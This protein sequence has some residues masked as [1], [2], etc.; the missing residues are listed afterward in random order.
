MAHHSAITY[1]SL[2]VVPKLN[3][4]GSGRLYF[5]IKV[6]GHYCFLLVSGARGLKNMWRTTRFGLRMLEASLS[7]S[8]SVSDTVCK[9]INET[10][11]HSF[12]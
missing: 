10:I 9:T 7:T 6:V 8:I 1:I 3:T 5:S 2:S 4:R 12:N 11:I